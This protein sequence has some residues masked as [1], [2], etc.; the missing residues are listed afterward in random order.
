MTYELVPS[1][2]IGPGLGA[3]R[4]RVN[5]LLRCKEEP[6]VGAWSGVAFGSEVTVPSWHPPDPP[7]HPAPFNPTPSSHPTPFNQ[8]LPHTPPPST[9]TLPHTPPP[10]TQPSITPHPLQPNPPSHPT[11]FNQTLPQPH[12]SESPDVGTQ[13]GCRR[14]ASRLTDKRAASDS[15]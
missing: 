4:K 1:K 2:L 5:A 15:R 3:S 10:S 6:L 13:P 14:R 8:T 7:S 11:P 9:P 12:K